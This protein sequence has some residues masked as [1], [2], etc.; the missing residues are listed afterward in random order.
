MG[1]HAPPVP[2]V[3]D[4][5]VEKKGCSGRPDT[6]TDSSKS[7]A[8]FYATDSAFL[9]FERLSLES[10]TDV[11]MLSQLFFKKIYFAFEVVIFFITS[12]NWGLCIARLFADSSLESYGGRVLSGP[13]TGKVDGEGSIT[14]G[15]VKDDIDWS[16]ADFEIE[17]SYGGTCMDRP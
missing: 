12:T 6:T 15:R 9:H 13:K 11:V 8:Q 3:S 2:S 16:S 1:R 17:S 5:S 10:S 4:L 14:D 7:V